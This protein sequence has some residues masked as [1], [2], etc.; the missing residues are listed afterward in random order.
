MILKLSFTIEVKTLT[1]LLRQMV[2]L[3]N[4]ERK[5]SYILTVNTFYNSLGI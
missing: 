4:P 2:G 1:Q 5:P 3:R